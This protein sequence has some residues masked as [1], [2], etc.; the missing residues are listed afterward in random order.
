MAATDF[1]SLTTA[2]SR[3]WSAE[4]WKAGRDESFFFSNG[5]IGKSDSDMNSVIQRVTKLTDTQR[6]KE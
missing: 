1:G 5:F 3:I 2:Q 4:L 6:G